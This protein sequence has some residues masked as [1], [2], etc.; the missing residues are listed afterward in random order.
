MPRFDYLTL[1]VNDMIRIS[2][3]DDRAAE[4]FRIKA[5]RILGRTGARIDRFA[6]L[7]ATVEMLDDSLTAMRQ[8]VADNNEM[9]WRLKGKVS[10]LEKSS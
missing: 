8:T 9:I 6:D 3:L 10:D 5:N 4:G 2:D 7:I 1:G